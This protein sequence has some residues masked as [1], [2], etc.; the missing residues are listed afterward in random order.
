MD[1]ESQ[2]FLKAGMEAA[3]VD[4]PRAD[5]PPSPLSTEDLAMIARKLIHAEQDDR[6]Q[7]RIEW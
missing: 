7:V 5:S 6:G 3:E 1:R 2:R 4:L